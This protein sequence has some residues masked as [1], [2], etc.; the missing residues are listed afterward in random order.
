LRFL[1][2]ARRYEDGRRRALEFDEDMT[3]MHR[4]ALMSPTTTHR[5]R[6]N[7]SQGGMNV[8]VANPESATETTLINEHKRAAA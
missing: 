1:L 6:H 3:T 7:R 2:L 4:R 8:S 5:T